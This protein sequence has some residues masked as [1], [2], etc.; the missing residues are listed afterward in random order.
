M[1]NHIGWHTLLRQAY[2]WTKCRDESLALFSMAALFTLVGWSALP[3]L[4][5]PEAWLITLVLMLGVQAPFM[6]RFMMG[7]PLCGACWRWLLFFFSGKP[8]FL[9]AE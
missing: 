2:L 4:K 7:R 1:D 3:W 6:R 8:R 9:A 5:R